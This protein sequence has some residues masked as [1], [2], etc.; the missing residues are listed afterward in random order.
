MITAPYGPPRPA[1]RTIA[2]VW[3]ADLDNIDAADDTLSDDERDRAARFRLPHDRRRFCAARALLR[4]LLG[5]RLGLP[6]H[7][8]R[9][10]VGLYGK[11]FL[12]GPAPRQGLDP[13]LEFNVSHSG[14]IAVYA[15]AEQPVGVDIQRVDPDLEWPALAQSFFAPSEY[16]AI[17]ALPDAD[18]REAFFACWTRKE[19]LVK[20]AGLGLS[21]PMDAFEVSVDPGGPPALLAGAYPFAPDAWTLY[22]LAVLHGYTACLAAAGPLEVRLHGLP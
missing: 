17:S 2:D 1:P 22:E 4:R 19:A 8:V 21:H 20:A 13:G 9:L 14:P 11:P 3:I 16:M 10:G 18:Q 5:D 7:A 12:C 15:V 6:A